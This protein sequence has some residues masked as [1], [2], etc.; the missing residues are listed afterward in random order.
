MILLNIL[1]KY[2]NLRLIQNR[3]QELNSAN[4]EIAK[5]SSIG[6]KIS[7]L[8]GPQWHFMSCCHDAKQNKIIPEIS[9]SKIF[10]QTSN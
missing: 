6:K 9:W 1:L 8:F 10:M 5:A 7:E 3:H 4:A 2:T